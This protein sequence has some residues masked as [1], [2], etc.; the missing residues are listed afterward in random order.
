MLAGDGG[1]GF[2]RPECFAILRD[3]LELA[4]GHAGSAGEA[5]LTGARRIS[6]ELAEYLTAADCAATWERLH[7]HSRDDATLRTSFHG[8]FDGLKTMKL[9][10]HLSAGPY[11]RCGPDAALPPLLARAGLPVAGGPKKWLDLLR[12]VQSG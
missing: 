11:P 4:A 2:Y 8:W 12:T 7:R 6:P 3:W 10:H 5:L 1:I 9:I